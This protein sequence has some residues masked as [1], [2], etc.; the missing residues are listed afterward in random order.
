MP[1]TRLVEVENTHNL[2]SGNFYQ[3]DELRKLAAFTK[4]HKLSLH[5][6]GAR[7]FNA[8]VALGMPAAKIS[9]F[10]D[11]VTFCLSKG[12]GAPVG[13]VLC[14]SAKFI[15]EARRVRK[16]LGGGMRQ[17]GILAAAGLY[18]LENNI[19][20]LAE[21][22]EHARMIAAA[23]SEVPWASLDAADVKT[24]IIFF[25]TPRNPGA[26]IAT[27]LAKK[28]VLCS[29]LGEYSVRMVTSLA[30]TRKDV[31]KVCQVIRALKP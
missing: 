16:L 10:A 7:L 21:D 15:E 27:A 18:A 23:L 29:A 31:E 11:T 26:E 17:A 22:H 1:R 19:D 8:S 14:G 24:N 20:R 13:S 28:G 12:L 25:D 30:V 5:M 2:E 9:G 4:K 6:D 3:L